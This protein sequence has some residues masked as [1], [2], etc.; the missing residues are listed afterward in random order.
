MLS[1]QIG[2]LFLGCL[3]SLFVNE[4]ES[5]YGRPSHEQISEMECREVRLS[6]TG[7]EGEPISTAVVV[8]RGRQRYL[9]DAQGKVSLGCPP[10]FK[11]PF[12]IEVSAAG[13]RSRSRIIRQASDVDHDVVLSREDPRRDSVGASVSVAELSLKNQERSSQLQKE[14]L[15]ALDRR[16][17]DKAEECFRQALELTPSSAAIC[18]NIGVACA[19]RHQV[20]KAADWFEHALA[21][22]PMNA[23]VAGNLGLVRWLQQRSEESFKLL[24]MASKRGYAP[25]AAR[26]VMGIM[27][28]EK[29]HPAEALKQLAKVSPKVFRYRDLLRS[30]AFQDLGN[31]KAAEKSRREFWVRNPAPLAMATYKAQYSAEARNHL[32]AGFEK[33]TYLDHDRKAP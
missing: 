15:K 4:P 20:A 1:R 25:A 12:M 14:G 30:I 16:D 10:G 13:Y 6:V 18:N 33:D 22:A 21:L 31:S 32:D 29:G 5:L 24:Q 27:T 8:V 19:R 7:I 26:Y 28:L 9:T 2:I 3:V 23:V 11:F 17:F